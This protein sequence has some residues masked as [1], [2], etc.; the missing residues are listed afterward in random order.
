MTMKRI[1]LAG[2]L[3]VSML[4]ERAAFAQVA[5][6]VATI[7]PSAEAVKFEHDGKTD[8]S[9]GNLNMR[10]VT[11][12]T[13]LKWAYG[14]QDSQIIGP[15]SLDSD[16]YDIVAKADG[17]TTDAQMKLMMQALLA[18][19]FKLVFHHDKKELKAFSMTVAKSGAKFHEAA[20]DGPSSRQ[21]SANGTVAKSMTMK[22]WADFLSGPLRTPVVD[23]TGL[24]GKYDFVLDFTTYLPQDMQSM[25]P[26][27]T[28]VLMA[29]LQ[30]EMGLKLELQKEMVDVMVVDHVEKP[31]AN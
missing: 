22:E 2:L 31:S 15:G 6:E 30:G 10:D 12:K 21:N 9:P 23:K 25:R 24:S 19:R 28:G 13:C 8:M 7:R 4:S 29:A 1:A 26:D 14:V 16:R 20:G 18:D 5:F 3:L 17:P 27:A 11:L